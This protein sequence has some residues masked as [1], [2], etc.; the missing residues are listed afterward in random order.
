MTEFKQSDVF[1]VIVVSSQT[2]ISGVR[3]FRYGPYPLIYLI[4]KPIKVPVIGIT[5]PKVHVVQ[6]VTDVTEPS[7]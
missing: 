4:A 1:V 5:V 3:A 6:P 2:L 7:R